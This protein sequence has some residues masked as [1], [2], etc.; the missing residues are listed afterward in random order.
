MEY[1]TLI[2]VSRV[3]SKYLKGKS[4]E[5]RRNIAED[6]MSHGLGR[7]QTS[8]NNF[9]SSRGGTVAKEFKEI[10]SATGKGKKR[11][12][13]K[14]V[15]DY[16][17]EHKC[18]LV[19]SSVDRL[20]RKLPFLYEVRDIMQRKGIR[21]HF[22]DMPE[23]DELMIGIMTL[24]AEWEAKKISDRTKES[25]AFAKKM[26]V[27]L[28]CPIKPDPA[29]L[30]S[31]RERRQVL[32]DRDPRNKQALAFIRIRMEQKASYNTIAKEL[33]ENKYKTR[34]GKE[35]YANTVR[36]LWVRD[37]KSAGQFTIK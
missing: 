7:Q 28:G 16:C 6:Y 20:T 18:D 26:G 31:A 2:R 10:S 8:V 9:I 14:D 12:I 22:A 27:K 33:N 21:V 19:V 23:A 36:S 1:V 34:Y 15:L 30:E 11:Y 32:A 3:N 24:L 29:F 13:I 4:R 37:Q 35:F 5:E 17:I 25:L